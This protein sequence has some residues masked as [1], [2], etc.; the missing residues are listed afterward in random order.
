MT[1]EVSVIMPVHNSEDYLEE[2]AGSVLSQ[3]HQNF[4]LILIDDCSTDGSEKIIRKLAVSDKRV[5]SIFLEKNMG[6]AASRNAGIEKASGQFIA[7]LDS[8]D[9]WLPEKLDRQL[10]FM[11][12]TMA[13]LTFT[14]YRKI[15]DTGIP[16]RII[17][18]PEQ[19][20]YHSLL[21]TNVIGMLTAMYDRKQ[22]GKR[23]LPSIRK[24]QDYAL[25]LQILKEGNVAKG[26]NEPLAFYRIHGNS[27]SRNK[28]DAARYQ[29]RVY[30]EL[31]GLGRVKSAWYFAHYAVHGLLKHR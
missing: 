17:P 2:A 10:S 27:I 24:R 11:K 13:S 15:T 21:K 6:P 3:Q 29:W 26:L 8:D 20:T 30:R 16:G 25:W 12:E 5:Q 22:L 31:E 19:V 4:E 14:A 7:F 1:P 18:V 28:V 9:I 23:L